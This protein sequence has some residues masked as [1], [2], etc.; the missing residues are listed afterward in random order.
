[1]RSEWRVE[2]GRV[3]QAIDFDGGTASTC[4]RVGRALVL[5]LDPRQEDR[6]REGAVKA[7]SMALCMIGTGMWGVGGTGFTAGRGRRRPHGYAANASRRHRG[8]RGGS[9]SWAMAYTSIR[10][11]SILSF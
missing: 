4:R 2:R 8:D 11:P 6:I 1:M 5:C 7:H 3:D 10:K 9:F